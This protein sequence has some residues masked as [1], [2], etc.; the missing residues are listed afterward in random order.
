MYIEIFGF[1]KNSVK[2]IKRL[3]IEWEKIFEKSLSIKRQLI[4]G[5]GSLAPVEA[6]TENRTS[7]EPQAVEVLPQHKFDCWPL[8]AYLNQYLPRSKA[9]SE[10]KEAVAQYRSGQSNPTFYLQRA[11]KNM[12]S[13]RNHLI[14][15]LLKHMRLI[16]NLKSRNLCF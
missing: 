5:L 14:Y 13:G 10:A 12:Y 9:E 3:A 16:E 11:F 4:C 6:V 1:Q 2:K 15:F 7:R 8:E